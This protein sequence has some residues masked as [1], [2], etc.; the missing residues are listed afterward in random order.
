MNEDYKELYR[1]LYGTHNWKNGVEDLF[2]KDFKACRS[3]NDVMKIHNKY[4]P[5]MW[6]GRAFNTTLK[7]YSNFRKII[8][9]L[10]TKNTNFALDIAFSIGDEDPTEGVFGY[11]SH[12]TG[13]KLKEK[14]IENQEKKDNSIAPE[15]IDKLVIDIKNRIDKDDFTDITYK[16]QTT[17]IVKAYHIA[18]LLGLA[19]GRRQVEILKTFA[20]S[21]RRG[22]PQFSGLVKKALGDDEPKEGTLLFLSIKEVKKYLT[23]LRK[24]IDVSEMENSE[25]NR[26]YNGIFN[27][28]L[29]KYTSDVLGD[30]ISFHDLRKIYA[31]YAYIKFGND[32]DKEMFYQKVLNHEE[33]LTSD[34][35][36]RIANILKENSTDKGE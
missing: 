33:K 35:T 22:I 6:Y 27:K 28:A 10:N 11:R 1:F 16:S 14:N 34:T 19:T 3:H 5:Y 23:M 30:K 7:M 4:M 29:K 20:V 9:E 18:I 13:K 21:T 25:I 17:E 31:N 24:I 2:K 32:G 15:N 12:L 36:Y 8:K 26:K